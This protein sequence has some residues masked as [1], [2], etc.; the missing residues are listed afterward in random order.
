M[1]LSL[2]QSK[3]DL[4]PLI[5]LKYLFCQL[6]HDAQNFQIQIHDEFQSVNEHRL[7]FTNLCKLDANN[8]D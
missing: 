7:N 2:I 5:L 4:S 6:S 1:L 3:R 8:V